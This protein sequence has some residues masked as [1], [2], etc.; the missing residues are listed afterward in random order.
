MAICTHN[1]RTF[2]SEASVEGL[3][4]QTRKIKYDV[5]GLTETRRHHSLYT[6][7]GSGEELFLGTCDSRVVGGVIVFFNTHLAMNID[8][9]EGREVQE[10][11][12][13]NDVPL[14]ASRREGRE[15]QEEESQND[16][17]LG[18]WFRFSR[19]GEKAAKFKKTS[20]RTTINWDLYTSL[21][22]LWEDAVMD[23]VDEEYDRFVHHLHDSAKGAESLKATRRRLSPETL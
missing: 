4:M 10:E 2:A 3:M 20:P 6:A 18:D 9:R 5:T 11:E 8:S 22:G 21:A 1:A 14:F 23:N 7:Y 17:Q 16:H 15:V 19:Q 13:Q 12:S